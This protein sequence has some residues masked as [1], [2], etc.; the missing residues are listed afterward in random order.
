MLRPVFQIVFITDFVQGDSGS[1]MNMNA[2]EVVANRAIELLGGE[3]GNYKMVHPNDRELV[4]KNIS[5]EAIKDIVKDGRISTYC[6]YMR[7]FGDG[8]R[9]VRLDIQITA[10]HDDE[11][12]YQQPEYTE[13]TLTASSYIPDSYYVKDGDKIIPDTA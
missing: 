13:V 12:E 4:M 9:W 11:V 10:Y 7:L 6:E 8:Y 5:K 3:K 2:N 1:S